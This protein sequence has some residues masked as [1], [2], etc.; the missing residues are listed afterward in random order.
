MLGQGT[1]PAAGASCAGGLPTWAGGGSPPGPAC[2]QPKGRACL[3]SRG[4]FPC[5]PQ[6]GLFQRPCLVQAGA[7][8]EGI[9]ALPGS[10]RA[11]D[12][13]SRA[14]IAAESSP[15]ALGSAQG[16]KSTLQTRTPPPLQY[17][18]PLNPLQGPS[19]GS[20]AKSWDFPSLCLPPAPKSPQR[21]ALS[22]GRLGAS[23][24]TPVSSIPP[25][26]GPMGSRPS[27]RAPR[28][29]ATSCW[30]PL[31]ALLWPWHCRSSPTLGTAKVPRGHGDSHRNSP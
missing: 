29:V 19:K 27:A 8:M 1:S 22:P 10:R 24:H 18:T 12:R 21:L 16:E 31:M 30:L 4:G 3:P 5:L 26:Q 9:P 13:R 28:Q 7:R 17:Q 20:T 14:G 15:W 6:Q 2:A 23:W 25:S 11:G